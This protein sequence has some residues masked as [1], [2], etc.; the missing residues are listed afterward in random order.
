MKKSVFLILLVS[1]SSFAQIG[2]Q[3]TL[4][5]NWVEAFESNDLFSV[6]AKSVKIDADGNIYLTGTFTG[7]ADFDP[8]AA[9]ANLT[10]AGNEDVFL[11]KYDANGGYIYACV[12]GGIENDYSSALAVDRNGN[13][14]I[15][16]S[17]EVKASFTSKKKT[18][19]RVSTGD[20]DIFIAKYNSDGSLLYV[21]TIGGVDSDSGNAITADDFGNVYVTGYFSGMCDFDSGKGKAN[22]SSENGANLFFAKYDAMGDYLYAKNIKGNSTGIANDTKGNVY[23]TGC[24][25][26]TVD[27]DPGKGIANLST[28]VYGQ[29]IFFAKYDSDGNYVF[30]KKIGSDNARDQSN[31]ITIDHDNNILLTGFFEKNAD[32]D[33]SAEIAILSTTSPCALFLAKYNAEGNYVYA[34]SMSGGRG[35]IGNAVAIDSSNNAYITGF[36]EGTVDFD[37]STAITKLTSPGRTKDIS[38]YEADIFLAKYDSNG[39]YIYAKSMGGKNYDEGSGIALNTDGRIYVTGKF[40]SPANFDPPSDTAIVILKEMTYGSFLASYSENKVSEIER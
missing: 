5:L 15:T 23:L 27:F 2:N 14:Y 18:I 10:S 24:F 20:F 30:A 6:T 25:G 39:K 26:S 13:A 32:F 31:A 22:L 19:N 29:I 34:K 4:K 38:G 11:A 28:S 3:I 35:A 16:G 21:N 1:L 36:F 40:E 7:T 12:I 9:T 37:P 8:S 33:P 17:F